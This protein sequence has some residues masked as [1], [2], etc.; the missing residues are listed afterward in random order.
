MNINNNQNSCKNMNEF[1][2][3]NNNE[4]QI[5]RQNNINNLDNNNCYIF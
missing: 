5:E 4:N 3:K 2:S 1:I